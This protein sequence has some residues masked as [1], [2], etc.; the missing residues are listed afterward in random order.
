VAGI[1]LIGAATTSGMG[2]DNTVSFTITF[3]STK[4]L[5]IASIAATTQANK[6]TYIEIM[7]GILSFA[8][9]VVTKTYD[10]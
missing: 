4:T 7:D 3:P 10:N 5:T 8:G 2:T 1:Y 6:M 9:I